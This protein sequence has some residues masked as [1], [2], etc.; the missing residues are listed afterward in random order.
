MGQLAWAG[1]LTGLRGPWG[2]GDL[3]SSY[4]LPSAYISRPDAFLS[5]SLEAPAK[6]HQG[7]GEA[8]RKPSRGELARCGA[9]EDATFLARDPRAACYF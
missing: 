5:P 3:G 4:V 1:N 7:G 8:A 2:P 9:T 6:C